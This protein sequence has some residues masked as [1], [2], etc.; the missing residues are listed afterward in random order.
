MG[1]G[2]PQGYQQ[3]SPMSADG[4][5]AYR[6][7]SLGGFSLPIRSVYPATTAYNDYSDGHIDYGMHSIPSMPD[8]HH[9]QGGRS[10]ASN[11]RLQNGLAYS[12][13]DNT[14]YN[15]PVQYQH[16]NPYAIRPG[17]NQEH[18]NY[19][20]SN[21]ISPMSNP[22]SVNS[23]DRLLPVP[24][25][26]PTQIDSFVRGDSSVQ[27]STPGSA[28]SSFSGMM[29]ANMRT[30]NSLSISDNPPLQH[31][32][33]GYLSQ[34]G[35]NASENDQPSP[36][37]YTSQGH[38]VPMSQPHQESGHW[39]HDGIYPSNGSSTDLSYYAPSND[40]P[41]KPSQVS[42]S[43]NDSSLPPLSSHGS[44]HT[45]APLPVQPHLN[46]LAYPQPPMDPQSNNM[47]RADGVPAM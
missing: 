6:H 36:I 9:G 39:S 44:I 47:R 31:Q 25:Q 32:Q 46:H 30:M 21:I 42:Q 23:N 16:S 14:Q 20:I 24:T 37:S 45:Y 1:G 10:W 38:G 22:A 41:R 5:N 34:S 17:D 29:G 2:F 11:G 35:S 43:S 15:N 7:S 3:I 18:K 27:G 28:H 40:A 19:S 33:S 13:L 26:R 12:N 4:I 8:Y